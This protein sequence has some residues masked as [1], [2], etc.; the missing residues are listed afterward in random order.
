MI[1]TNLGPFLVLL[2]LITLTTGCFLFSDN[3]SGPITS[4]T[5]NVNSQGNASVNFRMLVPH[6]GQ[7]TPLVSI[8]GESN[9]T[10]TFR[11]VI[12]NP[13]DKNHPKDVLTKT[14]AVQPDG[15]VSV[16]FSGVPLKPVVGQI[17]ITNGAYHGYSDF[18]GAADLKD[19]ENTLEVA[20]TGSRLPQD[21]VAHATFATFDSPDLMETANTGMV[22]AIN[23]QVRNLD[24][25]SPTVYSEAVNKAIEVVRPPTA[26]YY[27]LSADKKSLIGYENG[28]HVWTKPTTDLFA[29]NDLWATAIADM[30]INGVLRQSVGGVGY[31]AW[32]HDTQS[33]FAIAAIDASGNRK[34]FVKNPGLCEQILVLPDGSVIVGG[35]SDDKHC[36][37]L[38]RWSGKENATTWSNSG[39]AESGLTWLRYFTDQAATAEV[40]NPTIKGIQFDGMNTLFVTMDY[41]QDGSVRTYRISLDNIL[42]PVTPSAP[43]KF[44]SVKLVYPAASST[45]Q[46]GQVVRLYAWATDSDGYIASLA[47]LLGNTKICDIGTASYENYPVAYFNFATSTIPIG[48]YFVRAIA[49]DNKGAQSES[50]SV[51]LTIVANPP[52]EVASFSPTDGMTNADIW[53]KISVTF[54]EPINAATVSSASFIV[55]ENGVKVVTKLISVSSDGKTATFSAADHF[56]FGSVVEVTITKDIKDL[57]GEELASSISWSFRTN[58]LEPFTDVKQVDANYGWAFALRNDGSVWVWG[59]AE[60]PEPQNFVPRQVPGLE[61]IQNIACFVGSSEELACIDSSG[62]V[63]SW[64]P[65]YVGGIMAFPP[66]LIASSTKFVKVRGGQAHFLALDAGKNLWGWGKSLNGSLGLGVDSGDYSFPQKI[67]GLSNVIDFDAGWVHSVV[68]KEDGSVWCF[69][70]NQFGELG[71]GSSINSNIPLKV[72]GI[73]NAVAC[74]VGKSNGT[75][76]KLNDGTLRGWGYNY[77]GQVGDGTFNTRY[78]P[79]SVLDGAPVLFFFSSYHSIAR[80]ADG[81]IWQWGSNE[82]GGFGSGDF[83]EKNTPI[84]NTNFTD[85]TDVVTTSRNTFFIKSDGSLWACGRNI[86]GILGDGT[87]QQSSIPVRVMY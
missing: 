38:F 71:N 7:G 58:D 79:V 56:S 66:K 47:F 32:R 54:S 75:M 57:L 1:R 22:Q 85:F 84:Q 30:S 64:L 49:T 3:P 18:H 73:E 48:T 29:S 23:T 59:G 46:L 43:N 6:S 62:N 44:P 11:L 53:S 16:S 55:K 26:V 24:L 15:S 27:A 80:K 52:P 45:F 39:G 12:G 86:N 36:P 74:S 78:S 42:E 20:P 82:F 28:L 21:V 83:G 19:G 25:T 51:T 2:G 34:A 60:E 77:Y 9:T 5:S 8:H 50:F 68:V 81:T 70:Q 33:P 61:N 13:G 63:F 76:V 67:P 31:V 10:V 41:P 87:T 65:S 17:S 72:P 40:P 69:G 35:T 14:A 4:A 37:V